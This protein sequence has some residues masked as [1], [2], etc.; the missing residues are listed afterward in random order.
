MIKMV[1][2]CWKLICNEFITTFNIKTIV[3]VILVKTKTNNKTV[4]CFPFFPVSDQLQLRIHLIRKQFWMQADKESRK[5]ILGVVPKLS[6]FL[7]SLFGSFDSK[8]TIS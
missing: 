4:F 6:L 3:R 5:K 8:L 7:Q 2:R 1:L